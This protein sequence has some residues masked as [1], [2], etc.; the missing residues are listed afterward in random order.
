MGLQGV[1]DSLEGLD[2]PIKKLYTEVKDGELAGKFVLDVDVTGHPKVASARAESTKERKARQAV[3]AELKVYKDLGYSPEQI[4]E[5][6]R[7]AETGAGN[8]DDD[9]FEKRVTKRVQEA[10]DKVK[11]DLD[12][13]KTLE[14]ENTELKLDNSLRQDAA[15]AGML[16]EEV[17]DQIYLLVHGKKPRF[18]LNEK[19]KPVV[20]DD[21]GDPTGQTPREFFDK[22][23]KTRPKLFTGTTG[24]GSGGRG[25]DGGTVAGEAAT[26]ALPGGRMVEAAFAGGS[27]KK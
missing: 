22:L 20:L 18:K 11:P 8:K 2:E 4:A 14:E 10:L 16:P 19:G 1:V 17:E 6:K 9:D 26:R 25:S 24:G 12:R 27:T 21:E 23:K 13:V 5:A 3:E 7:K 15:A